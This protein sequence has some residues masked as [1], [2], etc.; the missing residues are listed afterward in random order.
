M[1]I[2]IIGTGYVGLVTGAC[3]AEIGHDVFC[4]D[5]DPRKID[6]L[7]NGG[8]PIHEPGLLDII[9]RNRAAGR[10][11]FSTDIEASVAHGE[12]QF[13]A[14]GTPPDEDGSADLQYVLE[15]ARNIGR[16]MTGFK[17]IVDK[18]T[19]PVGTAQRVRGVVDEA[20]AARGL[21]GSVAHRFSV[22][23]NPEFLKEGA[24]VEDFM[25]PDR[26][27][28]G[29]D[30][31]ETGTIAR[32]KMKKL[33]APF[34]RN[35][36][37]TIYMDVRSA[38]FAKYA[39]NAMLATRISFMNEM[40]NLADK[41]GAD[42]EAVRRGIGSD[43]RIGYHF[44]YAGVGYGGSCFP[45]DVQA[46]IRTAGENGQ[47][48]RILEAVEAANHAQKDVLIGKIEQRFGADLTGR[49]FAVWG[50]AFKPNTDDMR[51]AP[52]RRLIAALLERGATVRAY[53]PVAV[54]E[55]QRVFALDF[56]NDPDALAR[57]HL[58]ESQ[59]IAVTGA[60]ALVIVTEW[61]EF[62]SPDFTR[63]KAELKAPVIFDGR[64][65]YEPDAMAELGID[66]Y[67]IGRP[68][69]DPQSSTRG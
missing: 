69:V 44:L 54:D 56:G 51:E 26:I 2:T 55:A 24:A 5:V 9:A 62:R 50:L 41:V 18:S 16:Y 11:R 1:K 17:V 60:D 34:N 29:V 42:I 47:P 58:V 31:D 27:I 14:V 10:L 68:Y 46:L 23:S 35:H 38:E 61:K 63:L 39:A 53:D 52:S 4:L 25:R 20:L 28:I 6:I 64:N 13:I 8:M 32:E 3:L 12:I 43:P 66:Y 37:R 7:N 49:E 36:E 33:Y 21:A 30:D 22:V 59:D 19:V 65:L 57:L 67:A 15:A 48:L 45:K 40:S